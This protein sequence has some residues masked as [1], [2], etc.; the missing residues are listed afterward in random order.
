MTKAEI[1]DELKRQNKFD[2]NLGNDP[3]W[4]EAFNM[5]TQETRQKLSRSCG[6]CWTTIRSW[7]QS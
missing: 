2:S 1:K 5:Y 7:L 4:K 3:L 6:P